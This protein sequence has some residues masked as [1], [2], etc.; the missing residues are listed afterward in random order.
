MNIGL[1]AG[2]RIV[3]LQELNGI[4][5]SQLRMMLLFMQLGQLKTPWSIR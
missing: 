4:S 2:M 5:M 3:I 1:K